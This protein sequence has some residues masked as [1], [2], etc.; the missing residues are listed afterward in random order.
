VSSEVD[1]DKKAGCAGFLE[2]EASEDLEA[3]DEALTK[4]VAED[5]DK[6]ELVQIRFFAGLT[7]PETARV[8]K[9]SLATAES[10]WTYARTWLSAELEDRDN[11]EKP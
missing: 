4:L 7:M 8:L 2:K 1:L 9:I 3:V 6:A 11:S 10:H 5:P